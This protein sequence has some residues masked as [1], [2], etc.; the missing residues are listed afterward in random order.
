MRL[1]LVLCIMAFACAT[2][3]LPSGCGGKAQTAQTQARTSKWVEVSAV[4][5]NTRPS[6]RFRDG[7]FIGF[8]MKK[9]GDVRFLVTT[10]GVEGFTGLIHQPKFYYQLLPVVEEPQQPEPVGMRATVTTKSVN[11]TGDSVTYDLRPRTPLKP[12][13][14][15]LLYDGAGSVDI[16]VYL[17]Q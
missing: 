13:E 3:I 17:K 1:L 11:W 4:M 16:V 5:E 8:E 9:G 2:V 6:Q 12:G 14:Y 15:R 10:G 7:K